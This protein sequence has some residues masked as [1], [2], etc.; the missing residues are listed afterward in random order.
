LNRIPF[1][2]DNVAVKLADVL[3]DLLA[4]QQQPQLDI[5]TAYFSVRGFE[6]V[7]ATLPGVRHFRLLLGDNPQDAAAIGAQPN[8][9]AYLRN[10]LNAEPLTAA[11]QR[12]V[13]ELIRFLRRDAVEVRLYLGHRPETEGRHAFLHAKSIPGCKDRLPAGFS[14]TSPPRTPTAGAC[15]SGAIT[16]C[17]AARSL[18][19]ATRSC[20]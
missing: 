16:M 15:I 9:R 14:S 20:N 7:R 6:L 18:T 10:E 4:G 17:C 5:A 19:T 13:E 11:T 12:L 3:N 8:A 2:I 1:V